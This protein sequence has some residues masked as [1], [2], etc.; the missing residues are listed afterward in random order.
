ME[1]PIFSNYEFYVRY[2]LLSEIPLPA[3]LYKGIVLLLGYT[4][5]GLVHINEIAVESTENDTASKMVLVLGPLK[6]KATHVELLQM[7]AKLQ[8]VTWNFLF[9]T[10]NGSVFQVK[11][12]SGE[13]GRSSRPVYR[14]PST[15]QENLDENNVKISLE[16]SFPFDLLCAHI[17]I[18]CSF[19]NN[20][21]SSKL[22]V[23]RIRCFRGR[24]KGRGTFFSAIQN[25][26]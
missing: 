19:S 17:N 18:L 11:T 4:L 22:T 9:S 26:F 10:P 21:L 12:S 1:E 24:A 20:S 8:N 23:S 13:A 14:P 25:K 3:Q 7:D 2:I 16:E 5:T 15:L 6:M